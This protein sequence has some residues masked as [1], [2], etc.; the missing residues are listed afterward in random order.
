VACRSETSLTTTSTHIHPTL[1]LTLLLYKQFRAYRCDFSC[2]SKLQFD[3]ICQQHL[4]FITDRVLTLTLSNNEDTPGQINIFLS[5]QPSFRQ[6]I[7]LKS[8]S[9]CFVHSYET[10]IK[11]FHELHHLFNLTH[12][13]KLNWSSFGNDQVDLQPIVNN[14]WSLPKLT[15]CHCGTCD[16]PE[17]YFSLPTKVSTFLECVCISGLHIKW[18]QTHRSLEYTPRLKCLHIFITPFEDDDYK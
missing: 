4:P 18:N 2:F 10:L 17:K 3:M 14:I 6:F 11:I 16:D 5:Y 15:H 13:L 12:L 1:T 9:I 7:H 8:L